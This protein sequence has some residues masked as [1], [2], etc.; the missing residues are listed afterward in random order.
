VARR[1]I[2]PDATRPAAGGAA[3]EPGESA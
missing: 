2:V 3:A 1:A